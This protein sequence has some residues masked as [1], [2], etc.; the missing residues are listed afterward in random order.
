MIV[1]LGSPISIFKGRIA[2]GLDVNPRRLLAS[3]K[4]GGAVS[5]C[6][7]VVILSR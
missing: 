3:A 6:L 5:D 4:R 7:R 2:M 1:D